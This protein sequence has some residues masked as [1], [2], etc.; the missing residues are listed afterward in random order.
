MLAKT[1]NTEIS[2]RKLIKLFPH[3]IQKTVI[4]APLKIII[5]FAHNKPPPPND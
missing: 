4:S 5:I 2:P 1:S 3:L